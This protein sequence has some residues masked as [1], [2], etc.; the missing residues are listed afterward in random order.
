MSS[1]PSLATP[2]QLLTP[3]SAMA[4]RFYVAPWDLL[5]ESLCS[6]WQGLQEGPQDVRWLY[7]APRVSA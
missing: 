4:R 1:L 5:T 6:Q 2:T 3:A 7:D